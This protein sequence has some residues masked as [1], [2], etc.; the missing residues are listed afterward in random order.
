MD[1][2]LNWYRKNGFVVV[3]H[4]GEIDVYTIPRARELYVELINRGEYFFILD[5]ERLEFLDSTGLGVFGG[6]LKRARA[7]DGDVYIVCTQERIV[8]IFRQTGLTKVYP[9]FATV[10]EASTVSPEVKLKI[11]RR[12]RRQ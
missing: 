12:Y 4:T 1:L 7:H 8:K 5:L 2:K 6:C 10:D 11:Q 3:E 9:I